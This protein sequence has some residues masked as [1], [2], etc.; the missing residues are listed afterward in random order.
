MFPSFPIESPENCDP[1]ISKILERWY[2]DTVHNN[3]MFYPYFVL[4]EFL[5]L[6]RELIL[7]DIVNRK[8]SPLCQS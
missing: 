8:I 3:I 1:C 2:K 7:Q 4:S 5:T 6:L